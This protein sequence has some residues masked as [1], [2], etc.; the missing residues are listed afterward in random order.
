QNASDDA[1]VP[2]ALSLLNGPAS[3]VLN[4]PLSKLSQL[5]KAAATPQQRMDSLYLAFLSR[6]PTNNER[7]MLSQVIQERGDKATDDVAHALLAGS[8]FL[9]IQ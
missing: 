1:S 5:L 4:N 6:M 2:Q 8:Q 9:F 7:A 3:E